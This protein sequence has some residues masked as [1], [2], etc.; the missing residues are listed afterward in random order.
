MAGYHLEETR[1]ILQRFFKSSDRYKKCICK[2]SSNVMRVIRINL[3]FFYEILFKLIK[4]STKRPKR[5]R[6]MELY[7]HIIKICGV[8]QLFVY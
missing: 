6:N 8:I 2:G 5:Y 4:E 7:F 3:C 1:S